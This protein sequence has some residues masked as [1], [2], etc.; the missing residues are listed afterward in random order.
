MALKSGIPI[1]SRTLYISI[2][3]IQRR[4]TKFILNDF[5]SDYKF[6]LA[7][8]HILPLSLSMELNDIIFMVKCLQSSSCCINIRNY[9]TFSS[10]ATRSACSH[11]M[12]HS[13]S[14][15]NHSCNFYFNCIPGMPFLQ[16]ILSCPY[17]SLKINYR[18][19]FGHTLTVISIP[20]IHVH[21][22]LSV[23]AMNVTSILFLHNSLNHFNSLYSLR[24]L[25][26]LTNRPSDHFNH[27]SLIHKFIHFYNHIGL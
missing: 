22:I 24:L 10:S 3:N 14:S 15:T 5:V 27:N 25:V 12:I 21:S 11:K 9:I 23:P 2:E 20:P 7:S 1:W 26:E 13:I 16:L 19:S 18:S 8:L 17:L 6:R 4:V